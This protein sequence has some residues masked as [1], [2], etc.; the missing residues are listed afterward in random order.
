MGYMA[1]IALMYFLLPQTLMAAF[2]PEANTEQARDWPAVSLIVPKLLVCVAVYSIVDTL[3]V[4]YSFALRGAGDTR[5][6]TLLTFALAWPCMILPTVL[7]VKV[8]PSPNSVYIAWGFAS[9][10]IA[11]MG[12]C[13]W[14]RFNTGKWK[15]MRVIEPRVV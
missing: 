14:W 2:A 10:Y 8:F 9:L 7:V 13:F 12:A 5:F 11:V 4:T 1:L 3:N 6:V 15:T